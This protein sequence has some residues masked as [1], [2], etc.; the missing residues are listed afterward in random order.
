MKQFVVVAFLFIIIVVLFANINFN[1]LPK[2]T[3][4]DGLVVYKSERKLVAF[5]KGNIIKSYRIALGKSP[6]GAKHFQGDNKTPEGVYYINGRNGYS[7]AYKN[8]GISYPNSNDLSNSKG[9]PTGGDIKIHGLM[10]TLWF[11]GNF[12]R[13][14]D[15]TNGCI[16][17]NNFEMDELYN[18]VKTR[19]R[20]EIRP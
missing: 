12:H 1:R 6:I 8:L 18:S 2:N 5:S 20:I 17:V 11:I 14:S 10:N 9:K 19:T 13:L 4:I 7:I 15:W 16:A 3:E